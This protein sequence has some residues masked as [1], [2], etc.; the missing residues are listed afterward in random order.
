VIFWPAG[1]GP[2]CGKC[3]QGDGEARKKP[4][5]T[6]RPASGTFS[7]F[8]EPYL[9]LIGPAAWLIPLP[10]KGRPGYGLA[11]AIPVYGLKSDDVY[12]STD[13]RA[14]AHRSGGNHAVTVART[15]Q[16]DPAKRATCAVKGY[17]VPAGASPAPARVVPPGWLSQRRRSGRR[18]GLTGRRSSWG[19]AGGPC[20]SEARGRRLPARQGDAPP[21]GGQAV[22]SPVAGPR[23]GKAGLTGP[24]RKGR[25]LTRPSSVSLPRRP[26]RAQGSRGG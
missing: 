17:G 9:A 25:A 15:A 26:V 10:K 14:F 5:P 3:H 21:T 2:H 24:R 6:L 23:W 7:L 11:G 20:R 13:S 19:P 4:D 8:K 16:P 1:A 12:R 18:D 22:A